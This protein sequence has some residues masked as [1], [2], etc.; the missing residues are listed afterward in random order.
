MIIDP[1]RYVESFAEAG[2]DILTVH[3]E[4][5][6]DTV[7]AVEIIRSLGVK[8]GVSISPETPAAVLRDVVNIADLI[9]IMTVHPG[10]A[11]QT[12]IEECC[13]KI[14]E[15][16]AMAKGRDIIIQVDGGINPNTARIAKAYG[17]NCLVAGSAV[18]GSKDY[19]SAILGIR[20]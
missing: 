3:H 9:L 15:V 18:F 13:S 11:G 8:A 16:K 1:L 20:R 6:K 19:A 17:A 12:F 10:F 5:V 4:T 2:A 7:Q 14:A